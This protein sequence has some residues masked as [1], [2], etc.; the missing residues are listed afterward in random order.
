MSVNNQRWKIATHVRHKASWTI[1]GLIP[2]LHP[3]TSWR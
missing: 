3:L 2:Q 1:R